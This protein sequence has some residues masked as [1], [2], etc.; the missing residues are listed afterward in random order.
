MIISGFVIKSADN[1]VR[2]FKWIIL[3][4]GAYFVFLITAI[5]MLIYS[6]RFLAGK[7]T[8]KTIGYIIKAFFSLTSLVFVI[9][10]S[11]LSPDK[12]GLTFCFITAMIYVLCLYIWNPITSFFISV[13]SFIIFFYLQSLR[14]NVTYSMKING[15]STWIFLYLTGVNV[16][17]QRKMEAEKAEALEEKTILLREKNVRDELTNLYNI[18]H[19]TH[20]AAIVLKDPDTRLEE[21]R[22]IFMDIKNFKNYNEKYGFKEGNNFL[23]TVSKIIH[24]YFADSLVA[25]SSDDHFVALAKEKNLIENLS[26][27]NKRIKKL[28]PNINV[29]I[30]TGIYRPTSTDTSPELACDYARYACSS[31]KKNYNRDYIEYDYVMSQDFKKKQYIINTIENAI[32]REY[33]KVYYQPVVWADNTKLCGA[34]ALARWDDPQFGLLPPASFIPVLE[35]YH[36]IH[37]LDM[38]IMKTVCKD[39]NEAKKKGQPLL[40]ISI[41][42]SRLDF[43]LGNPLEELNY[44]MDKYQ[45]SKDYIHVEITES[46]LSDSDEKLKEILDTI[47]AEGYSLW[48]DDFGSGYSGLNVLKD[49]N[50]DMMKIDM[51]F[52]SQFSENKKTQPILTSIVE[53][54]QK[55]GINTLTEGVETAEACDFLKKIGCQRLQGYLFGKPMPKEE[56]E[57]RIEDGSLDTSAL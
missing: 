6:I 20:A 56:F 16:Y 44:Y 42:F 38:F 34:E 2:T 18:T 52:L 33:I 43:D 8:N 11:Y 28:E 12:S 30:K 53:L 7:K 23:I 14:G 49:F 51:K 40:P 13:I 31:I 46:A 35:E 48:L 26:E 10:I 41:N 27:I 5:I 9:Y 45:I 1:V 17:F 39:L 25:R 54:A 37:K 21:L 15:F 4:E 47:R 29:G 55:I 19:F 57:A 24:E 36:L 50:F 32:E 3:H 22:F